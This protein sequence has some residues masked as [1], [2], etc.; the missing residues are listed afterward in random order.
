[1]LDAPPR[2]RGGERL[3]PRAGPR[4]FATLGGERR[5][6]VNLSAEDTKQRL[7]RRGGRPH[8]GRSQCALVGVIKSSCHPGFAPIRVLRAAGRRAHVGRGSAAAAAL[9]PGMRAES[10]ELLL[11]A[12]QQCGAPLLAGAARGRG[13][14]DEVLR[15]ERLCLVSA[16][17]PAGHVPS[18]PGRAARGVLARR[19]GEARG[20]AEM[21]SV[22]RG[23]PARGARSP[24]RPLAPRRP[25]AL[26]VAGSASR[27]EVQ[28][29]RPRR[30]ARV[31]QAGFM[32]DDR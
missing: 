25:H 10:P 27:V 1:M 19:G 13:R 24:R 3:A 5:T 11:G 28:L 16:S 12:R 14:G 30:T 18:H 8:V 4:E 32:H 6:R 2:R 9:P 15:H 7:G 29:R 31:R 22:D 21:R 17:G 23:L 26:A 20:Q